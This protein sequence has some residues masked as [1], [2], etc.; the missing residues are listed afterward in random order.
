MSGRMSRR[1]GLC[2]RGRCPFAM[3]PNFIGAYAESSTMKSK[4]RIGRFPGAD[5]LA[6]GPDNQRDQVLT[7]GRVMNKPGATTAH[8]PLGHVLKEASSNSE[9]VSRM[10]IGLLRPCSH[11]TLRV[12]L[13]LLDIHKVLQ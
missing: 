7:N 2:F 1:I 12:F 8:K 13:I 11:R 10:L 6:R 4:R 5:L 3:D 9:L